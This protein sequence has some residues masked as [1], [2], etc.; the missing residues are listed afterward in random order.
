M[1][2]ASASAV[3]PSYSEAFDTSIAVSEQIIDWNS[4]SVCR[5]PWDSSGW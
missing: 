2:A 1:C 3:A 5:T 4:N